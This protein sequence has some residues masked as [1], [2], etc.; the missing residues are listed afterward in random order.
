MK[1][2]SSVFLLVAS[3]VV[4]TSS[5]TAGLLFHP[6]KVFAATTVV[7]NG[8]AFT[9]GPNAPAVTTDQVSTALQN[10]ATWVDNQHIDF[11]LAGTTI[12]FA[13]ATACPTDGSQGCTFLPTNYG[14]GGND[15]SGD[16]NT[17][18][19]IQLGSA[20]N[21]A[22]TDIILSA[23]QAGG[24]PTQCLQLLTG[25]TGVSAGNDELPMTIAN[26][27]AITTAAPTTDTGGTTTATC[28]VS[29]GSLSW[30]ICPIIN[31]VVGAEQYIITNVLNPLLKT[32]LVDTTTANTSGTYTY[33]I[34][35]NFR[36]IGDVLLI[37]ALLVVVFGEA[38]GGGLIDAYT[39]KKMLPRILIAAILIN[40]SIYVVAALVDITNVLGKGIEALILAPFGNASKD[41]LQIHLSGGLSAAAIGT[42]FLGAAAIFTGGIAGVGFIAL[43]V[44]LPLIL[45]TIGVII[46]LLLRQGIILFLIFVSPVAFALYVLPNTEQYFRKWWDLLFKT[47][48]IYPLV[49]VFFAMATVLGVIINAQGGQAGGFYGVLTQMMSVVALLIPLFLVPFAFRFAGGIIGTIHEQVENHRKR[50]HGL[51]AG[52]VRDPSSLQNRLKGRAA[53]SRNE[54][55]FSGAALGQVANPLNWRKDKVTGQR[56]RSRVRGGLEERRTANRLRLGAQY[57]ENDL[58]HQGNL[59]NDKYQTARA[60]RKEAVGYL[61]DANDDLK[62]GNADLATATA[63]GDKAGIQKATSDINSAQANIASWQS[64]INAAGLVHDNNS[65][66]MASAQA[67]AATGYNFKNGRAGY[68]QLAD[69]MADISGVKLIYK[70][71]DDGSDYKDDN[72]DRHIE[73]IEGGQANMGTYSN[74]MNQAQY[75]LRNAGRFDL[76]GINNGAEYSFDTGS[77]KASDYVAGAQAKKNYWQAGGNVKLNA[78]LDRDGSTGSAGDIAKQIQQSLSAGTLDVNQLLQWHSRLL[79]ASYSATGANGAEINK[80]LDAIQQA[81][82]S[83]QGK[84]MPGQPADPTTR[85]VNGIQQN[86]N[87]Q[88]KRPTEDDIQDQD[89]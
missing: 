2:W 56:G 11:T 53:M 8:N 22:H 50:V 59:N 31:G 21:G 89:H 45:A 49:G 88:R 16:P 86:L 81:Q 87:M 14:C 54:R 80:Q 64:A 7:W 34:W 12:H 26:A 18:M 52:D 24:D 4:V 19:D 82:Y 27:A 41:V 1:R 44:I 71:N 69:T 70:K 33:Q 85:L 40:L 36:T 23:V 74:A 72:G 20:A 35:S 66:R 60:N 42:V 77:G 51:V 65:T 37:I 47:L 38:I 29:G 73:R 62:K 32:P 17:S 79:G 46:T 28:E 61:N 68:N 58:V 55:Y 67:W 25:G 75:N 57:L 84:Q 10:G 6:S 9:A 43:T 48:L 39:A 5:L 15:S 3:F 83:L 78:T 63:S 13:D 76:A 30:I